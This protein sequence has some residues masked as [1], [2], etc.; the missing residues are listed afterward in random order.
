MEEYI[1]MVHVRCM[2]YNHAQYI[3][4]AMNGF[5]MQETKFPFVCTI[6]DDAS[7]DGEQEVIKK[8]LQTNFNLDDG[9][10]ARN[11]ET[12]D[13]F[14]IFS[15][16]KRNTNCFFVVFFLKYNHY[17]IKK[18]KKPYLKEWLD[19]K[20]IATCEGDDYWIDSKKLQKQV[21]FLEKNEDY[22][23]V[24]TYTKLFNQKTATLSEG[25]NMC[26]DGYITDKLLET[27]FISTLT[28]C[29]RASII[30]RIDYSYRSQHFLMGDLPLWIEI[31]RFAKI[32][33]IQEY[34]CVYR[35]LENSASHSTSIKKTLLFALSGRECQLY[36]AKKYGFKRQERLLKSEVLF[37]QSL[38]SAFED[39]YGKAVWQ[40]LKSGRFSFDDFKRFAKYLLT[41]ETKV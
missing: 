8:Y 41:S 13:Y 11:E 32:G 34:T 39:K 7:T 3:E 1:Y 22:G 9:S 37:Q 30:K 19:S 40:Y 28:V 26:F 18:S 17:S 10:V 12:D 24:Y 5:C 20:Y 2:T 36:F 27:Y 21:D 25:K 14:M 29:Y 38:L 16:H 15:Q 33:C 35:L 4:D 31:S 23:L 6:V